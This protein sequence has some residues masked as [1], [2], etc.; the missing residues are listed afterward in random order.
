MVD[1]L[2]SF[3]PEARYTLLDL[4]RIESE[5]AEILGRQVDLVN[6]AALERSRNYIHRRAI[7]GSLE[8]VYAR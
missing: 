8:P 1:V 5:L 3:A 6:R 4:G 7:L 2:V